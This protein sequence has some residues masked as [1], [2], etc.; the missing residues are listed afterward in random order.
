M[1]LFDMEPMTQVL[2]EDTAG[3]VLFA[4]V[5]AAIGFVALLLAVAGVYGLVSHGVNQRTREIGVRT[6]L[7]AAPRTVM[8]MVLVQGSRPVLAGAL[9]GAGGAF[10]LG[11]VA[12]AALT[13]VDFRDPMNYAVVSAGL[14]TIAVLSSIVPAR[15]AARV[16][17]VVALK[18]D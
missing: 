9:L 2:F 6:A 4:T 11:L 10:V 16:D 18:V 5:L 13:D 8:R 14:L 12:A 17:P 3:T 15:R 1:P 7:G